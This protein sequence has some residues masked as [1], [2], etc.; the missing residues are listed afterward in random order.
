MPDGTDA[1][2]APRHFQFDPMLADAAVAAGAELREAAT[3]ET[4]LIEDGRVVGLCSNRKGATEEVRARLLVGADGKRSRVARTVGAGAYDVHPA[5][6][7]AYYSYWEG[8]DVT[9]THLVVRDGLFAVAVPCGGG[10][11]FL[12]VQWPH[13]RFAEIRRDI[14]AATHRAI[15]GIPWLA[16]RFASARRVERFIGS[17]DLDTFFRTASGPGWA[18]VGDSGNQKELVSAQGMTDALLDA[19]LLS[20]AVVKGLGGTQPLDSAL[21]EYG[22]QRDARSG[23]MHRITTDLARLVAPPPEALAGLAALAADLLAAGRFLGVMAGSVPAEE[24]FGP[25]PN[26]TEAA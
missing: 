3:F 6:T 2:F 24:V 25:P 12:A 22:R 11:T 5:Q 4:P 17:G 13:D 9:S 8:A 21:R 16:E 10:L 15:A 26:A 7:C 18:L 20:A 19:E 1:G 23:P 14:K